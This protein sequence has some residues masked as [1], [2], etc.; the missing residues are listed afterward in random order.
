MRVIKHSEKDKFEDWRQVRE[1]KTTHFI[2]P[3]ESKYKLSKKN[4]R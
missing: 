4:L 1:K 2:Q 3:N